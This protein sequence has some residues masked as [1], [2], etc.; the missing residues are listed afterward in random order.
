[1]IEYIF[2]DLFKDH[3]PL[4]ISSIIGRNFHLTVKGREEDEQYPHFIVFNGAS[5]CD[6]AFNEIIESDFYKEQVMNVFLDKYV[7]N[8]NK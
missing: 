5:D 3:F 8:H 1:M 2:M 4:Q 6:K 7:I